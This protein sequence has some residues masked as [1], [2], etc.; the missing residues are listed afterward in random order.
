MPRQAFR[1]GSFQQTVQQPAVPQVDLRR[2]D[3]PFLQVLEPGREYANQVGPGEDVEIAAG[4]AFARTERPRELRGVPDLA[5]P[6]RDHHPEPPE[7]LGRDANAQLGEIAL[8]EGAD[9]VVEPVG[10]VLVVGGEE[11]AREAAPQ[12]EVAPTRR[13]DFFQVEAG[14]RDQP[15]PAGQRL[16]HAAY[17]RRRRAPGQEEP[18]AVVRPVRQDAQDFEQTR[19]A[20]DL[21]HDDEA[22]QGAERL[23]RGGETVAVARPLQVEVSLGALGLGDFGGDRR[24]PALPRAVEGHDRMDPEG[25]VDPSD[26]SRPRDEH[27][28][29]LTRYIR[30]SYTDLP[31]SPFGE[32]VGG[33][34][35]AAVGAA[36]A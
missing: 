25:A 12:P 22:A 14:E 15:D 27:V 19:Q 18:R 4:R 2:A 6:V 20:L 36:P 11:G 1:P 13:P 32:E 35:R 31:P 29:S 21:V 10:C 16:G 23:F 33:V 34:G 8:Q 7:R 9:E 28:A 26:D 3:L 17:E 30:S 5:V 24:L